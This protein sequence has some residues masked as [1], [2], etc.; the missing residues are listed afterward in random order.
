MKTSDK[1]A[2]IIFFLNGN[3]V[4]FVNGKQFPKAQGSWFLEYVKK[5]EKAGIAVLNSEYQMPD[6]RKATLIKTEI[7][8]NWQ[9]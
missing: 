3:T 7:G 1:K 6:G 8:Y 9:F 2:E 5:L 4:C